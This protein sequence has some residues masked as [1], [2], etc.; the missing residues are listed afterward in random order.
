MVYSFY[1]CSFY[2]YLILLA[3]CALSIILKPGKSVW[4]DQIKTSEEGRKEGP[5]SKLGKNSKFI[6]N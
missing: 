2:F 5:K 3:K 4:L 1:G 6:L